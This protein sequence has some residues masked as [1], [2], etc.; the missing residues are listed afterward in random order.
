MPI[1]LFQL[2]Q[3][4]TLH[5]EGESLHDFLIQGTHFGQLGIEVL[6]VFELADVLEEMVDVFQLEP[7]LLHLVEDVHELS[8]L[9]PYEE[10]MEEVVKRIQVTEQ[11][12]LELLQML[13]LPN[14][15]G[16]S[17]LHILLLSLLSPRPL[18]KLPVLI[19]KR[20]HFSLAFSLLQ[21][22]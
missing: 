19:E 3:S 12:D 18:D 21:L 22:F 6:Q 9:L 14:H 15:V 4:Y 8:Y 20:D 16:Y 10:V 17:H 7:L 11:L 5:S 13:L 1:V 2:L